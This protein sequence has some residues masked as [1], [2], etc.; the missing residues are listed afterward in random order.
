M[1]AQKQHA[2]MKPTDAASTT[3][4][5]FGD[6]YIP[7]WLSQATVPPLQTVSGYVGV[8]SLKGG[9]KETFTAAALVK[10]AQGNK[11]LFSGHGD[12]AL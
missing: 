1:M 5:S 7:T 2:S 4:T 8:D 10:D 6:P 9:A 12:G 3:S 11:M